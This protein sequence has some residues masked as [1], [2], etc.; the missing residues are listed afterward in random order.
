MTSS[1][2]LGVLLHAIGGLAAASFYIPFRK[3]K[4][5]SWET[6]WLVN[7][8]ASWIIV[9]WVV[10][11]ITVPDTVGILSASPP[12]TLALCFLFGALWGVG[13][14]T[15]G[16]SV[17][18]LGMSLGYALALGACAAFGTLVPPLLKNELPGMMAKPDGQ[19]VLLGVLMSLVGIAVCGRAG[20]LKERELPDS[21]KKLTIK[22]F[23]FKKGFWVALF[24]GVM[25]ACMSFG[26]EA[27]KPIADL[28]VEHKAPPLWQNGPIFIVIMAGGFMTNFIW[29]VILHF[30]NQ[31]A[32][33]YLKPQEGG[34]LPI[35]YLFSV[36]AG[37]IW[38]LQF[39]FYGMG[40]TQLGRQFSF[41]SWTLHMAFIIIFSNIWGLL[42]HEWKAVS[43]P[44]HYWIRAGIAVL[45]VSTI[46][47]G[48]GNWLASA[49]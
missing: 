5:W 7:G 42:F 31:S 4:G 39:M 34:S 48:W 49:K 33:Q 36:L 12:K 15:F 1:P 29:C 2:V 20:I 17:R 14:L 16:L 27:G 25:S 28:A 41:S 26:I 45:I 40:S 44:T 19:V 11:L 18:Y 13:G 8:F 6:Y 24:C 32:P 21:S 30:Q 37:T 46:I 35:N 43:R 3:V 22:E 9:P 10:S 47:V 38:Y 23:D